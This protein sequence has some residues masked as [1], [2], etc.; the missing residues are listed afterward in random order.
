VTDPWLVAA[1]AVDVY[2]RVPGGSTRPEK[3]WDHAAG[4]LLVKEAGG[5]LTDLEGE[6]LHFTSGVSLESN[7]GVVATNGLLHEALLSA[8]RGM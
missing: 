5:C 6:P 2:L 3:I 8:W 7:R 1:G 4:A